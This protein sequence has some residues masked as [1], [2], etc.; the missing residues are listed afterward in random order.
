MKH[1]PQ[2]RLRKTGVHNA[3]GIIKAIFWSVAAVAAHT[4]PSW[5]N[6]SPQLFATLLFFPEKEKEEKRLHPNAQKVRSFMGGGVFTF[7]RTVQ[8]W[9]IHSPGGN[10]SSLS[11]GLL[12]GERE[13]KEAVI[14][15][16][17]KDMQATPS[18]HLGRWWLRAQGPTVVAGLP[19]PGASHGQGPSMKRGAGSP[20]APAGRTQVPQPRFFHLLISKNYILLA[21]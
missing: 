11:G 21:C 16:N 9:H 19:W 18:F 13:E 15:P 20:A 2:P 1:S 6:L 3:L 7:R 8:R 12:G 14:F 5:T 4:R 17:G 10:I